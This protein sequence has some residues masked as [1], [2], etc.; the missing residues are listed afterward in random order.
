MRAV[1]LVLVIVACV[2]LLV[3]GLYREAGRQA[4][5]TQAA[6]TQSVWGTSMPSAVAEARR[7]GRLILADFTGSDWCPWCK[8]LKAEVFDTPAFGDWAAGNVVLLEVDFP[9]GKPQDDATRKQ[10]EELARK[11]GVEGFPTVLFLKADGTEVGRAGYLEGGSEI[12][13]AQAQKILHGGTERGG[14]EKT[15]PVQDR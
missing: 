8:K 11:Y 3:L 2:V 15:G 4:A 1:A 9:R 13:I 10:N 5:T 7:T 6:A 14:G 12:W